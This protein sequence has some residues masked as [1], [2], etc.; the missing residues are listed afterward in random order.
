MKKESLSGIEISEIYGDEKAGVFPYT[1]GIHP[2]MYR[3][4]PW[5]MRQYAGF[6]SAHESNARYKY[7]LSSGTTGLSV[8]F[9][10]PTQM[11]RDADHALSKGEVGKVGVS[12]SS[13]EEME[14]LFEGIPLDKVS[15]SMTINS[16]ASIVLG[17]LLVLA[18][19]RKIP[20]GA[21]KGTIQNDL[22]KE[23]IARGTYIFPPRPSIR[24][25]TDIFEFCSKEVTEWNTISISG[26]HIREAGSNAIQEVAF[27]LSNALC[28]VEAA[29]K[30]GLHIDDFAPRLAFFFNCH[31]DFFEEIVKFRVAR[32]LY[33]TMMKERFGA[34]K[35]E[36]LTLRFHTQTAGSSL[37]AQQPLNNIVRTSYQA[38]AATLGGTQSLHTNSFD[39]ALGLPTEASAKVA[40]RT[41]QVL[42]YETGIAHTVDPLAGSYFIEALSSEFEGKVVSLMKKIEEKGGMLKAIEEGFPQ[43]EI[44]SAAYKYQREIESKERIIVG[45]NHFQ[46]Q[47]ESPPPL[48]IPKGEDEVVSRLKAFKTK[49]IKDSHAHALEVLANTARG[50]ANL[51]P[52]ILDAIRHNATLGEISDVLRGVFGEYRG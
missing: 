25:I 42:L 27:T 36:S 44:E 4:K 16:T 15:I 30:K 10:L 45:V 34:M 40:L 18:E 12:V 19:K 23:Y 33:A 52:S 6:G 5:T 13:L 1:R 50:D 20:W 2:T 17:F 21:L 11:G 28:Y 22:L 46:E 37:T 9:D 29:L 41:Q 3:G 43:D 48:L 51:M 7:L 31:N 49:R 32:K 39:E 38:L 35:K 26:Y 47:N 8:A 14:I 24:V